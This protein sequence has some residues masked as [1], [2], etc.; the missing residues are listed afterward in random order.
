MF[1]INYFLEYNENEQGKEL[2]ACF[3]YCIYFFQVLEHQLLNMILI[4]AKS[5]A[6]DLSDKEYD[7]IFFSYSDKAMGKLIKKVSGLYNLSDKEK[8]LLEKTRQTR[9]DFVHNYFKNHSYDFYSL[10]KRVN[11][12]KEFMRVKEQTQALDKR[13]TLLS[14]SLMEKIGIS[15]SDLG[16]LFEQI[17]RGKNNS[18]NTLKFGKKE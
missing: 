9:N 7:E 1:S 14:N 8:E 18:N 3:G 2:Y 17:R 15:Q 13:L 16:V 12:L 5:D 11:M 10:D 6:I 4:K